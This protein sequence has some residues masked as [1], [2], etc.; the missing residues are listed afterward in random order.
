M[1]MK[2]P[3]TQAEIDNVLDYISKNPRCVISDFPRR[4]RKHRALMRAFALGR[5]RVVPRVPGT[6]IHDHTPVWFEVLPIRFTA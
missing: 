2:K 3:I 1:A 6:P 4:T 5:V